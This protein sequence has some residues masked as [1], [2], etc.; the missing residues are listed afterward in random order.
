MLKAFRTRKRRRSVI[1]DVD[2]KK[3]KSDMNFRNNW[4]ELGVKK[5]EEAWR[6]DSNKFNAFW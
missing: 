4:S 3:E 6:S 1:K 5:S 2:G